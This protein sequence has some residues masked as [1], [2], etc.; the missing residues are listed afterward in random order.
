MGSCF[1]INPP[2]V[3]PACRPPISFLTR[4]RGNRRRLHAGYQTFK[5]DKIGQTVFTDTETDTSQ[6]RRSASHFVDNRYSAEKLVFSATGDHH[7]WLLFQKTRACGDGMTSFHYPGLFR[8]FCSQAWNTFHVLRNRN[9][10][11]IKRLFGFIP[12]TLTP[13]QG[14]LNPHFLCQERV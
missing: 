9:S 1:S 4:K 13:E 10:V 6:T 5:I 14:Q 12:F 11:S 3:Q 8:V 2:N 7:F